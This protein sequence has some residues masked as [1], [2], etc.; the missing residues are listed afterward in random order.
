MICCQ[1]RK[2]IPLR[3]HSR[4]DV[5]IIV[6]DDTHIDRLVR[7]LWQVSAHPVGHCAKSLKGRSLFT[8]EVDV[9]AGYNIRAGV[10]LVH[11][12]PRKRLLR[13]VSSQ[14]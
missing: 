5:V 6:A 4:P 10:L 8:L 9:L 2:T 13:V 14:D 12:K 7:L 1:W 3:R 11:P